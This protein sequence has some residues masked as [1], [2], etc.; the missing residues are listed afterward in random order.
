MSSSREDGMLVCAITLSLIIH[1]TVALVA[2][3]AQCRH[4]SDRVSAIEGL[5]PNSWLIIDIPQDKPISKPKGAL[6]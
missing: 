4:L 3:V 1:M 2:V 6:K 5:R